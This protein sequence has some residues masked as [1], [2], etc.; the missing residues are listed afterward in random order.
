MAA[1]RWWRRADW[2]CS[3][4][5]VLHVMVAGGGVLEDPARGTAHGTHGIDRSV[6]L[7]LLVGIVAG[8]F[9]SAP[10]AVA[11][12]ARLRPDMN[13]LV[14]VSVIGALFLA[15]WAEAGGAG[16]SL[17]AVGTPGELERAAGAQRH[18]LAAAH[19]PG[20]GGGGA[21][22]PRAPDAGG[23]RRGRA[24]TC[25]CGRGSGVPCDGVVTD[26][27]SYVDQALVTGE[28]V[29]AWKTAGDEVFAGGR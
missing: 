16:L 24:R 3:P 5:L 18:R 13:A 28:S 26:G 29:P 17:R 25:G 27:S 7:L 4:G 1:T 12:L 9:H 14:L 19:H 6:V 23:P 20:D 11:S 2:R 15:E 10:K 8:L 22:R 21:R